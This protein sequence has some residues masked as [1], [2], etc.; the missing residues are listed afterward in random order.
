MLRTV[1]DPDSELP[2]Y[3]Q[4]AIILG[5]EIAQGMLSGKVPSVHEISEHHGVSHRVAARALSVLEGEGKIVS[6][7]GEGHYVRADRPR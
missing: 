4:L 3:E 5:D 6:V 7:P 1:I 2:P